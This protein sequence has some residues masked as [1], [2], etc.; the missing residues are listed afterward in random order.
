LLSNG[1][2]V[3]SGDLGAG[4][5]FVEWHDP[6]PKPSY[7]FALVAGELK[8][9]RGSFTTMSGRDVALEVLVRPG[10]EAKCAYAMDALRRAMRWDEQ[11]Y[12]REYDLD[13]FMIVATHDFNMGAMENKGLNIFNSKY[14]LASPETATDR[15][16][17]LIEGIVAH[18]YFHNWTGNRITCRDWFQL[19]LKEGLTVFRDQQFSGDMRGHGVR[20][21]DDVQTLR[22][23]QFREDQGPLAH[24]VR[25]EEYVEINNFYTATVYEKGAE[26]IRMLRALVG[27]EG[28]RR[29][30][31]LYF[32]R[33]DGEAC[34]I[35]DFRRCFEDACNTDLDQFARWWSQAG[36]PRVTAR[37][38]RAD[39][40]LTVTLAQTTPPTPGQPDKAPLVIPVAAGVIGPDGAEVAPTRMLVLDEAEKRFRFEGIPEGSVPSLLRGFSA[41]VI[42]EQEMDD[43]VRA[44]LIAHDTDPFNRWEA[45]HGF[46]LRIALDVIERDAPVPDLWPQA[47][48][49]ALADPGLDPAFRAELLD[50]PGDDELTLQLG[51]A[52]RLADPEKIFGAGRTLRRALASALGDDLARTHDEMAVRGPYAPDAESAGRRALANRSMGL[53]AT[54]RTPEA[55]ARAEQQFDRADNMSEALP[56]LAAL[57]HNDAPD[58]VPRLDGFYRRWR[59]DALVVQKWLGVQA[60]APAP[61]AA[62]RVAGLT[63]HAAFDWRN[64]NSFR[65]LIG[66]F[67][68]ANPRGFHA[69]DGSGYRLLADWLLRLDPVN[70][71]TTARIAG[72]FETWRRYDTRRQAAMQ[73]EMERMLAAGPSRNTR[74]ILERILG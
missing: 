49:R 58:A 73:A 68:M 71:Q 28:Y 31:D 64:P 10:D 65:A 72:A 70:P 15:D 23:R 29:A 74:E 27:P 67:A 22:A 24:P 69:A 59:D 53:L 36:T 37:T 8:T 21:I 2:R 40:G 38:D 5:H 7:L 50:V 3:A 20:R 54:L 44:F 51:A 25:P 55:F 61:D 56:A 18:E 14:V 63:R 42:L 17:E 12:G 4:R 35:E 11:I 33:H 62:G 39:G 46:A 52:G 43:E 45:A 13:L 26:V 60:T 16:F 6:F 32:E 1:N 30:L 47:L 48:G 41:P 9:H 19:C 66:S 34:T 57:V